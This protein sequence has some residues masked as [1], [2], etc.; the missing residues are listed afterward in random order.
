MK[1]AHV[2]ESLEVGGAEALVA[3]LCR[4]H[5]AAGHELSVHC[6][7]AGGATA[8]E[9]K[10]EGFEAPVHGPLGRWQLACILY[11]E[12][13]RQ[14]P[15]VV[16]CHN[17]T[18]TQVAAPAAWLARA[19]AIISTRHGLV[20][21][22][23]P[24]RRELPFWLAARCCD[25]V[26]AV[27]AAA[28]TNLASGCGAVPGKLVTIRNG[29]A[30]APAGP[31]A[32]PPIGKEGFTVVHVARLAWYKDQRT[33]LRAVA[34]AC[35]QVPDL[36]VWIIGD[37]TEGPALRTLAQRLRL[38]DRVL[39]LGQRDDVGRWLAA[40]DLFVLCSLTEGLPISLLEAMAAGLPAIVTNVGG[41]AEVLRLSGAGSLVP[42]AQPEA[43]AH[44]IIQ[45]AAR[46][47]ELPLLGARARQCYQR[48]LAPERMA[49]DY[50]RLY[51]ECLLANG[52]RPAVTGQA[53][54]FDS[55]GDALLSASKSR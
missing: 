15:D 32:S 46:R 45:H 14:T 24:L 40:A 54:G 11:R 42:A 29:A 18:A 6:L 41:M 53:A 38:E 13:R 1:V 55:G 47:N 17:A 36:K 23:Y 26:V 7:Y 19:G 39:F 43:L 4:L 27:C 10:R 35:R 50:L 2:I 16:H 20:A 9:L 12:F 28:H 8:V 51:R 33:L 25:R 34:I 52:L 30:P 37:G 22:P 5:R 31:W 21:P 44:A 49:D 48:Y 3:L